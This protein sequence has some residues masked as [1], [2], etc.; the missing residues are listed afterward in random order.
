MII[1]N[2]RIIK[3]IEHAQL[4][5]KYLKGRRGVPAN[6][7]EQYEETEFI[8]IVLKALFSVHESDSIYPDVMLKGE[9]KRER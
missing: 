6:K 8:L 1:S 3:G 2:D 7:R 5:V 4:C 9:F